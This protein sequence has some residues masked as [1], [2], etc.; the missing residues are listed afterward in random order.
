VIRVDDLQNNP[1]AA[2]LN[3]PCHATVSGQ[4]N[5]QITG[6]WPG[7]AARHFTNGTNIMLM[8]TAGA[9][10]D[11]NPIY[12]PNSKFNDIEAIGQ[13][14]GQET[15]EIFSNIKTEIPD[16]IKMVQ[17]QLPAA[18]KKRSDSRMPNVSLEKADDQ[19]IRMSGCKIGSIVLAGISGEL[20]TEIGMQIKESSPYKNTFIITHCNGSNGYLCTDAAYREGGYEPMVSKTMPGTADAILTKFSHL[21]Q[22][23]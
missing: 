19:I 20:M 21:L 22:K 8:V 1:I 7:A 23:I 9:S 2:F 4:E 12:G 3:W 15:I 6:D 13:L 5:T 16:Q 18:G 11:I 17:S 14:V 10:A